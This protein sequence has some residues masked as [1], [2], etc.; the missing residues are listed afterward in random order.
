MF[1][2]FHPNICYVKSQG[3][4]KILLRG[5]IED[6]GLYQFEHPFV[7]KTAIDSASSS[8]TINF[9]C[10]ANNCFSYSS[11]P[12][13]R[14]QCNNVESLSTSPCSSINSNSSHVSFLLYK[15]WH[16]RLDHPH[17]AVLKNVLKLCNQNL[18]NK[19]F[20]DFCSA[21]CLGKTHR[22]PSVS[23]TASYTKSLKLVFCYLWGPASIESHEGYS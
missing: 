21:Y 10:H 23:S 19:S 17:H 2:E 6:Y 18:P 12:L 3:S 1:F 11:F 13:S 20:S 5:H 4:S 15:V 22:L 9:E 14:S 8:P 7:S 16:N